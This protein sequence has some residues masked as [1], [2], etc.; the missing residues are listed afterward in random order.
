MSMLS[1]S[2]YV[3]ISV[4]F[5]LIM[6]QFMFTVECSIRCAI[7]LVRTCMFDSWDSH[8]NWSDP[9]PNQDK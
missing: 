1:Y 6:K 5:V 4:L 7:R 2:I 3:D 8:E 9:R